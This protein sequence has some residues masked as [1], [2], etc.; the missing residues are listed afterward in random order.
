[1][2]RG[3][4]HPG[5]ELIADSLELRGERRYRCVVRFRARPNDDVDRSVEQRQDV[6]PHD[7]AQ[8][9]LQSISRDGGVA[10]A[11][12]YQAD[13][14]VRT[15][16][17]QDSHVEVSGTNPLPLSNDRLKLDATREAAALRQSCAVVRRL[18]ICPGDEQ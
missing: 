10:I 11:R 17:S 15:R 5:S 7:F 8:A 3:E 13:A 16:G 6:D 12:D 14:R 1:M 4:N 18:R 9:A 2:P